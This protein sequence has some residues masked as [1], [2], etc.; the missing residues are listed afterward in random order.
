MEDLPPLPSSR[1][2]SRAPSAQ[3]S[4]PELSESHLYI[5]DFVHETRQ[6]LNFTSV[7]LPILD[8]HQLSGLSD[9]ETI[10]VPLSCST[11]NALASMTRQLDT[12]TTQLGN[13]QSAL[14]TMPTWPALQGVIEPINAAI[15]DLSHRVTAP[16]PQAPA[17]TRPPVPPTG[18]T[19][20]QAPA[21]ARPPFPPSGATAPPLSRPKARAPP[22]N[23]G[24]SSSFDP[25]IPRYDVGTR[26]FYGDPR[27]YAVKFPDYWE[28]NAFREGKY[29][30]PT[31][32]IPG[33]L[34]PDCPKPQQSYAKAASAGAPKGKK[35]KSSLTAAQ[36]ASASIGVPVSQQPKSLPTAERRFYAPRSS[37]SEHQQASLI[38]ATFPDI[39]ARVLRDANCI[40]P[41]AV[42]T[43][44][45]DRGS[46]TLL[47]TDPATPAA[48]LAPY[49]GALSAQLNKS[50]PVGESPWLP[51][52]LA[53]NEAQLAIHSLPIAF[54][55]EDPNEL[56]P[57]LA[58]SILNSKNIRILAA[59]FLN[60]D[61]RS[62]ENKTAASVIVS[63]HPGDVPVMG[64][65][66]RLFS[67]SRTVERAYSSNR[68]TQCKNC[69]GFGHVAPRCPSVD[70][71]CPICSLNHTRAMHRCPNPTCPGGGNTKATP[72]CCSS[73]PPR[74]AQLR[75]GPHCDSQGL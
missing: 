54:L 40:L 41:L 44:V 11:L 22:P 37:P 71:V 28:A 1:N 21:T 49:S 50:F 53:P 10:L 72:G 27:A 33:H 52:R 51:F 39:A 25:D 7:Q 24:S 6:R 48:A 66:I 36:V 13:I 73:S 59:R 67:R 3:S 14:H 26:S 61:A 74:C 55:P 43:K 35:N 38:A 45:N 60:P 19:T 5:R 15:R 47:V 63:V 64:S 42:T 57:C 69:W 58:E 70:P 68:Y 18:V 8:D 75:W 9:G 16:P 2:S 32:F 12:I 23:K 65:S 31:T 46:V 56:F 4:S 30:D 20:H 34:A 29:P 62:R 17:P